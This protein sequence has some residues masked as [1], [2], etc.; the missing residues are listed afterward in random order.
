MKSP[1]TTTDQSFENSEQKHILNDS[2]KSS[3]LENERIEA[4]L[5]KVNATSSK[6]QIR[7]IFAFCVFN[8]FIAVHSATFLFMFLSPHFFAMNGSS[9]GTSSESV[10]VLNEIHACDKQHTIRVDFKSIVSEFELFC[11]KAHVKKLVQGVTLLVASII[12]LPFVMLQDRFGAKNIIVGCFILMALPGF[13]LMVLVDGLVA[14]V[15]GM[16]GLWVFN[17]TAFVLTNVLLNE[18]LVEPYRSISNVV[19]KVVYSVGAIMGTFMT[20]YLRDYKQ[21][22]VLHFLGNAVFIGL[23]VCCLPHS[24][25]FLL[26]QRKHTKLAETVVHIAKINRVPQP[27]LQTILGT[28]DRIIQSISVLHCNAKTSKQ[29]RL[30]VPTKAVS[31]NRYS[32][33]ESAKTS[34]F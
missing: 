21:I 32:F 31:G 24:A 34:K 11:A 17:D 6:F 18:Y 19:S 2:T 14:K 5:I 1:N 15:V 28:L 22:T 3:N 13:V 23:L 8:F 25:F 30:S 10:A 29:P 20:L 16:I 4:V 33:L 26:K 12:S 9:Q 7:T 27:T